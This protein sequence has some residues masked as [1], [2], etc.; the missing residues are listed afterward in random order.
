MISGW[1]I[2]SSAQLRPAAHSS[3]RS[4]SSAA[5]RRVVPFPCVAWCALCGVLRCGAVPCCAV[6]NALLYLLSIC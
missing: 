3:A 1:L 4:A 6:V 2:T 5:Q